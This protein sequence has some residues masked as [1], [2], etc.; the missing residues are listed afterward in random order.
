MLRPAPRPRRWRTLAGVL[1]ALLAAPALA[2]GSAS[3]A[4]AD[5]VRQQELWV[6]NAINVAGAWQHTHGSGATVALIDSGVNGQVSDLS[7]AVTTGRDFSGVDTPPTDA[8]WGVHGTWMASLIAGHGHAGGSSGIIGVAPEAKI[9]SIRAVTDQGDPGYHHY[10]HESESRVQGHLADAINYATSKRVSVISMSL[11]YQGASLPV[12]VAI[13][14]ALARG[15][16][17]VASSGN[18]GGASSGSHGNAPYSFPADYPGVLGV[19]AVAQ[20]GLPAGFS[21]DNLSVQ[22]AAPGVRVPAQGRDSGYWLVSGTSPACA[23]TAGVAAL[24]KSVYPALA[25]ALVAQAI[26]ASTSDKP[27]GGYDEEVGFGTVDATA[28]LRMAGRLT[29]D[30]GTGH[31]QVAA[32][33]FGGGPAAIPPIPVP[34]RTNRE[35]LLDSGIALICLAVVLVV[36]FRLIVTRKPA[37]AGV[38]GG[39]TSPGAPG[40][41]SGGGPVEA[42]AP[43]GW[44]G[45]GPVEARAPDGWSG[46]GPADGHAPGG[47]AGAP[48]QAA[49]PPDASLPGP[50]ASAAGGAWSDGDAPGY[51]RSARYW[52]PGGY[53]P[54][55]DYPSPS[56]YGSSDGAQPHADT[57]PP[58]DPGAPAGPWPVGGHEWPA[59]S[60]P[61][62]YGAPEGYQR[63]TQ[64]RPSPGS[65][66]PGA[67]AWPVASGQPTG[68][69]PAGAKPSPAGSGKPAGSGTSGGY[70]PWAGSGPAADPGPPAG[71]GM[72]RE[73]QPPA[74]YGS[75]TGN[76]LAAGYGR[77]ASPARP[78]A[79]RTPG[80]PGAFEALASSSP[81]AA[82]GPVAGFGES[83]EPLDPGTQAGDPPAADDDIWPSSGQW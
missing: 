77:S 5:S 51:S 29:R 56:G 16:V 19:G 64:P 23:L 82:T 42:R 75:P 8:N 61:I 18:S 20:N 44:S 48:P 53:K 57:R 11:G 76:G 43:G 2:V 38:P 22:V 17:V 65:A 74:G 36:A 12:R 70:Q 79:P 72:S 52:A 7:G 50:A 63:P 35:F 39:R 13:S 55:A 1:A 73:Q 14:K 47:W 41:W 4:Q 26:T 27:Q 34:P 78:G 68:P 15:I 6:L 49:G 30:Q 45:A 71:Y 80:A 25:P 9:L 66:P 46:A 58:A 40:A 28:A 81:E 83:A 69:A 32:A 67:E 54:S 37:A 31:G 21:S 3:V 62:E 59:A 24:I 33:Q 60:P 10:Q